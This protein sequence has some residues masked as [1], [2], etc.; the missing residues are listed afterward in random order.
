MHH[1]SWYLTWRMVW[2]GCPWWA[3]H[4]SEE[5]KA[6]FVSHVELGWQGCFWD[7]WTL[8]LLYLESSFLWLIADDGTRARITHNLRLCV[9]YNPY[10][11]SSLGT[12]DHWEKHCS[13]Q[14]SHSDFLSPAKLVA[15]KQCY[16]IKSVKLTLCRVS[17]PHEF[18]HFVGLILWTTGF[19]SVNA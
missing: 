10:F 18:R 7:R 2:K 3:E 17:R 1:D 5:R 6:T 14:L 11:L 15:C 8:S 12:I 13:A 9:I 4:D 16:Q 19:T